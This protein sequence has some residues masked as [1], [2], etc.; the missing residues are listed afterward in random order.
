M[1]FNKKI[2]SDRE[3]KRIE[4]NLSEI[5]FFIKADCLIF[6]SSEIKKKFKSYEKKYCNSGISTI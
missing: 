2:V 5:N 1:G 4:E 6:T 3:I